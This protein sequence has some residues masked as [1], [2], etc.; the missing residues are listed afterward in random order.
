MKKFLVIVFALGSLSASA[1]CLPLYKDAITSGT[2]NAV[3]G[4][5]SVF[6]M[7]KGIYNSYFTHQA[8][9]MRDLIKEAKSSRIGKRTKGLIKSLNG[10]LNSKQIHRKVLKGNR[11]GIF[12]KYVND[13]RNREPLSASVML[14]RKFKDTLRLEIDLKRVKNGK[15]PIWNVLDDLK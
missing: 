2:V 11:K 12:C 10:Q 4:T 14:Y 8:K 1:G 3:A 13:L 5:V 9:K 6:G 7:P 15:F